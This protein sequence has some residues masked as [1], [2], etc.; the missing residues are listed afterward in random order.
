MTQLHRAKARHFH[1]LHHD[2]S[3]LTLANAWDVAS[4]RVVEQAGGQAVATT[5]AGVAR[6]LGAG[7]GD[8][9]ARERALRLTAAVVAAVDI[10]VTADI[11]SGFAADPAGVCD[12]VRRMLAAGAVGVTIEDI[13]YAPRSPLRPI[14]EQAERIAAA[15]AAADAVD[16][17]L[18]VNA[19][20]DVYPRA[21]VPPDR[22][23]PA[24]VERAAAYLAAGADGIYVPGVTDRA[25]IAALAA[26]I[27]APLSILVDHGTPSI[28]ELA[29]LGV[30]RVSIGSTLT[31]TTYALLPHVART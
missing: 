25:T 19:R 31:E 5:S 9:S 29:E 4:A 3:V 27:P 13:G 14:A 7:D 1:A 2:G 11:E 6:R 16:V 17:P 30:A 18:F 10:P 28:A 24:T 8:R 23:I 20:I 22:R 12:T 21:A 26:Q 15:R